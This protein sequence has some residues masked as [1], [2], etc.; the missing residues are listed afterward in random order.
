MLRS[1]R[2]NQANRALAA[3]YSVRSVLKQVLKEVESVSQISSPSQLERQARVKK[4][5]RDRDGKGKSE[6]K[7]S[8]SNRGKVGMKLDMSWEKS[9]QKTLKVDT[10]AKVSDQQTLLTI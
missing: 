8:S 10:Q 3:A 5:V 1:S 7:K 9:P 4:P 6:S 2:V